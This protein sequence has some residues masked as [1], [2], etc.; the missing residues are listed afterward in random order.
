MP[1]IQS[2]TRRA[3]CR[4]D[5]P[6][7]WPARRSEQKVAGLSVG[8]ADVVI[9]RLPG[10]FGHLEPHGHAGLLLA[11]RRAF[12]GVSVRRNVLDLESDDIATA[13]LAVDRQIE[14]RQ[15]ALAVCD[16]ELGPDR[17]DVLWP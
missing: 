17:P 12:N 13:Q 10:L 1:R 3:Y 11:H 9:D 8:G 4:V 2:P 6:P 14:H 5:R 15:V 16:L 7:A